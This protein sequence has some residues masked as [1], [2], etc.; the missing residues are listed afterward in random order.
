MSGDSPGRR[1]NL[2]EDDY[3]R[4]EAFASK[5]P[6]DRNPND[7]LPDGAAETGTRTGTPASTCRRIREAMSEAET[8]REVMENYPARTTSEIMRHA[9]GD[10]SHEHEVPPTA[11]PTIRVTE[12]RIFRERFT[13]GYSVAEIADEFYRSENTITRHIF[14]R[15]SHENHPRSVFRDDVEPRECNRLREVYAGHANVGVHAVA[16]AM[17]MRLEV[18]ASHLFG[19][20]SCEVET[21]PA[22]T[23]P[24]TE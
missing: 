18:A 4:I 15:C 17:S 21:E 11:S 19:Y 7:L 6:E 3:D 1:G 23:P 9:Y 5:A 14:G 12:C 13:A 2:T 16:T 24:E 22:S 10:C 20:C 8:V